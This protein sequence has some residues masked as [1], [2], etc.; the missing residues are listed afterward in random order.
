[1]T[2]SERLAVGVS[3]FHA[4]DALQRAALRRRFPDADADEDE[5][6]FQVAAARYGEA[7]AMAAY[8]RPCR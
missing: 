7:L 6:N 2:P 1:M 4:G 3:L 8:K 5:I